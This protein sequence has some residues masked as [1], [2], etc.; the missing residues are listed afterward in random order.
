MMDR[1]HRSAAR[2]LLVAAL[3]AGASGPLLAA[4]HLWVINE[5]YSNADGTIQFIEMYNC[6]ADN[7]TGLNGRYV[8][9]HATN[10]QYDFTQNLPP[11]STTDKYIL[12]A[13][14]GFADLPGAPTPDHVIIDGFFDIA[15]DNVQWWTYTFPDSKLVFTAGQMPTDGLHSLNQNGSGGGVVAIAT[16]TN[17]AGQ[18]FSPPAVADL[19]VEKLDLFPDASRLVVQFDDSSCIGAASYAIVYGFGSDFPAGGGTYGL[20]PSAPGQCGFGAS[21]KVWSGVP[22]PTI[23]AS[24]LLWFL[25]LARDGQA[26]EGSWGPDGAGFERAGPGAGGSSGQCGANGKVLLNTCGR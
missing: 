16:P 18:T 24:R 2:S 7:E 11:N 19:T 17:F 13:T 22:D 26:N 15:A 1:I 10:H 9:S 12:L 5:L 21:P 4:S 25:V 8:I 6:C 23:D 20:G 14:Q 3:I